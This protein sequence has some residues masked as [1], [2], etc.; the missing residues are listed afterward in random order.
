MRFFIVQF[1]ITIVEKL[2]ELSLPGCP[3]LMFNAL[4]LI[5]WGRTSLRQAED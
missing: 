1:V 2:A 5:A 4:T 3:S